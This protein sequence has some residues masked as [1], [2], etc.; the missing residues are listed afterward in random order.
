MSCKCFIIPQDV[1]D[2]F[3]ADPE[4][5][6]AIRQNFHHSA[7]ISREVRALREQNARLARNG[8]G[9]PRQFGR[10]DRETRL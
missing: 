9:E 10:R 1:L 3:A 4:L 5:S 7:A 8:R 6:D 2:R